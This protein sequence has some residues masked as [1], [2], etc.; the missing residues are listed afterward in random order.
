MP[1][2]TPKKWQKDKKEKKKEYN[3][4]CVCF[5]LHVGAPTMAQWVKNPTVATQVTVQ[6]WVPSPVWCSGLKDPV[7]PQL[8]GR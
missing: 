2:E 7:S 3:L 8:H 4:K 6:V 5:N 1:R